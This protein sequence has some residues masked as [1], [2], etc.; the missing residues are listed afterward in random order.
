MERME[1]ETIGKLFNFWI[2]FQWHGRE[3]QMSYYKV[4]NIGILAL[5]QVLTKFG[6]AT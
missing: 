3:A 6:A 1:L 5:V 2:E 4:R